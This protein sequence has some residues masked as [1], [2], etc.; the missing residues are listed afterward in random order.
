[1][2]GNLVAF[3]EERKAERLTDERTGLMA[4]RIRKF[5]D[6]VTEWY[7]AQAV[8]SYQLHDPALADFAVMP[9]VRAIVE[10]PN[11]IEVTS[12]TFQPVLEK[13]PDL[14]AQWHANV[15]T[16]VGQFMKASYKTA[17]EELARVGDETGVGTDV[18]TITDSAFVELATSFLSFS[19]YPWDRDDAMRA[20]LSFQETLVHS[21]MRGHYSALSQQDP[22]LR[23]VGSVTDCRPWTLDIKCK[24]SAATI[25]QMCIL[26]KLCGLDW[27]TVTCQEMDQ[28]NDRFV[29]LCEWCKKSCVKRVMNWRYIVRGSFYMPVIDSC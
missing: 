25:A 22:Y 12:S 4:T 2:R 5:N 17:L 8:P 18:D 19:G 23:A 11:E 6:S 1:M 13:L 26:A 10:L 20:T 24:V 29:C 16:Q 14:I 9:E 15:K 3:L 28:R 27:R 21:A 7:T